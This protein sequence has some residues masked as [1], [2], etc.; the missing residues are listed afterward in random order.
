MI[1]SIVTEKVKIPDYEY[2]GSEGYYNS[3]TIYN[4]VG[5]FNNEYYRFGVVYIY[6]NGT[7]SNV[8][9]TL[10]GEIGNGAVK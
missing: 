5:Y 3:K 8:Y 6:Q 9:N 7:L 1:P 2:L 4:K 10:G